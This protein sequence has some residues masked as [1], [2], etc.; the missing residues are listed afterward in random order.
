MVLG[1]QNSLFHSQ[2]YVR[3]NHDPLPKPGQIW[4]Q[5]RIDSTGAPL[6]REVVHIAPLHPACQGT[7]PV[8]FASQYSNT[9]KMGAAWML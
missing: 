6:G 1:A 9:T 2:L 4:S 5:E 7:A 8:C 3:I